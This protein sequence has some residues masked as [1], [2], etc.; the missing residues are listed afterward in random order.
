VRIPADVDALVQRKYQAPAS[1][2]TT[3]TA[4]TVAA[5]SGDCTH[6]LRGQEPE[7]RG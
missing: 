6:D 1:A 2:S 5:S 7:G 3:E 4:D